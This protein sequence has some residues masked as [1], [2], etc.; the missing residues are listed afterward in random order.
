MILILKIK[1]LYFFLEFHF[2]IKA[3]MDEHRTYIDENFKSTSIKCV[4]SQ[5]LRTYTCH[6]A[7]WK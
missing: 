1:F 3:Y 6:I 5:R 2:L 7:F 4:C